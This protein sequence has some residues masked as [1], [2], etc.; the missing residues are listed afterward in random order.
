M[1][2]PPVAIVTGAGSGI[3]RTVCELMALEGCRLV[4]V[5][6]TESKL[7]GTIDMLAAD[8]ADAP[9]TLIIAADISDAKQAACAVD[10]TLEQWGR[11]DV[12]I[13][14]AGIAPLVPINEI[15]EDLL[16]EI[17]A[18]NAFG[19]VHLVRRCWPG[20]VKHRSGCVVNVSSMAAIDPFPGLGV[21]GMAKA[22]LDGL[23]RAIMNEGESHGIS[24]YSIAPG[25]VETPMLRSI[26]DTSVIAENQ[27]LEPEEVAQVIV[28]CAM[29]RRPKDAGSVITI[30]SPGR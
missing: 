2:I 19:P 4:L 13:N 6:R 7:E 25:A 20:F 26:F 28:D 5:G 10:M 1:S 30:A 17:F 14:N 8:V 11:V 22:A 24:A 18:V 29:G 15:D 9:Q 12:L 16:Y 27:T 3:G 23:T 21:Y